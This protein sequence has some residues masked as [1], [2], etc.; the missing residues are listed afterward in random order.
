M[1]KNLILLGFV[2]VLFSCRQQPESAV[3]IIE[4]DGEI[5]N[6]AKAELEKFSEQ[7]GVFKFSEN[8]DALWQFYLKV[9]K[10][11]EPYSFS[12]KSESKDGK[13]HVTLKGAE[14]A[15]LLHSVYSFLEQGGYLFEISGPVL[16][17][18]FSTDKLKNVEEV[19]KP[20]VKKRGIRQHINFPMDIS[21]YTIE[22]AKTYI[23]NLA[24]MRFNFINFHSYPGMWHEEPDSEQFEYAGN[25]FYG[26][27]HNIPDNPIVK[28]N[29]ID[30]SKTFCIP[31]I[32]TVIDD[33]PA[34]SK[35]SI[36]WLSALM[37]EAKRCGLTV[38]FSFESRESGTDIER[39]K[40]LVHS[41]LDTYPQIDYL[42]LMTEE[43]GGWGPSCTR[44]QT[45][46][47]LVSHFGSEVLSDTIVTAPIRDRQSDL[48]KIFGQLGHNIKVVKDLGNDNARDIP[49]LKIGIYCSISDYLGS[50]YHLARTYAPD[51]EIAVLPG[52]HSQRVFNNT[53]RFIRN[54]R[55]WGHTMIYSWIEFD[56]MMYTQQNA[57]EGIHGLIKEAAADAPNNRVNAILFNH[58][59]TAEN[60]ITARYAAEATLYGAIPD[61]E[62]YK[63][64]A[65]KLGIGSPEVF[66]NVMQLIDEKDWGITTQY[67]NMGFC[68]VGAWR[69]GGSLGGHNAASLQ[70]DIDQ[71]EAIRQK[72]A[73]CLIDSDTETANTIIRFLDNRLRCSIMYF[74]AFL[75]TTELQQFDADLKSGLNKEQKKQYADIC[76]QALL[77]FDQYMA[78]HTEMMPDRGCEGTLISIYHSPVKG[79]KILRERNGGVSMEEK[80]NTDN[81]VDSPPLPLLEKD[82]KQ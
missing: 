52:H 70:E 5:I 9:D 35:K 65:A 30:N 16:A 21:S 27:R 10:T 72:L 60:H 75:K 57:I 14:P 38:Q 6:F 3:I 58:W 74:R 41:I 66:A 22:D 68:W 8:E 34:R 33:E 78:L 48:A 73:K 28:N 49:P 76:N 15:S 77:I 2:V 17:Q 40:K 29:I 26:H 7:A 37:D 45:R 53:P 39:T 19:I 36:E 47:T 24:R 31:E 81:P 50:L 82:I 12:Y 20:V 32:E 56:G 69:I 42:E 46:N 64:Y 71:F 4:E 79:L 67:P 51:N 13:T 55:D 59:R 54:S 18:G 62:F 1:K 43:T 25:F 63:N 44:E 61:I 11:M 80:I 23:Q